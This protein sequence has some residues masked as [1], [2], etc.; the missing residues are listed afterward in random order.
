[1]GGSGS[2]DVFTRRKRKTSSS[3]RSGTIV[4][5][6]HMQAQ[7]VAKSSI[8][9]YFYMSS[10]FMW[11]VLLMSNV[12]RCSFYWSITLL[13]SINYGY[14]KVNLVMEGTRKT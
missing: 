11:H 4:G 2:G 8:V 1:M 6:F 9:K 7:D 10:H 3:E 5:M 12:Q 14:S 13:E